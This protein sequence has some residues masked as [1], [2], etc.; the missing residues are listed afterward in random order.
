MQFDIRDYFRKTTL[1]THSHGYIYFNF[2]SRIELFLVLLGVLKN[3]ILAIHF[4]Y[5]KQFGVFDKLFV[6]NKGTSQ[7]DIYLAIIY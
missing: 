6:K 7:I 4:P 1:A 2:Y 5:K 3:T